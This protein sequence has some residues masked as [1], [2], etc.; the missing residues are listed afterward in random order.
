[1]KNLTILFIFFVLNS[2]EILATPIGGWTCNLYHNHVNANNDTIYVDYGEAVYIRAESSAD[3]GQFPPIHFYQWTLNNQVVP[4]E[5]LSAG[6]YS[7]TYALN[8]PG[9]W[10]FAYSNCSAF[11]VVVWNEQTT[12][13]TL[14][15]KENFDIIPDH[16]SLIETTSIETNL[17]LTIDLA[18]NPTRGIIKLSSTSRLTQVNILN[19]SGN[20]IHSSRL[21]SSEAVIDLTHLSQG[22]YFAQAISEN[23]QRVVKRFIV[24][25]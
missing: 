17:D 22:V 8:Q 2:A 24:V 1:M 11:I 12:I 20:V 4:L 9:K 7:G 19:L 15:G 5:N 18:P 13:T 10:V 14:A 6:Y 23:G 21:S 25:N 16:S 3:N